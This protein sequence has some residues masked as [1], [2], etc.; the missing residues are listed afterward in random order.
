MDECSQGI[1][2]PVIESGNDS[3]VR[4]A[5]IKEVH[6]FRNANIGD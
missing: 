1:Y 4:S 5:V 2:G 3:K 6:V